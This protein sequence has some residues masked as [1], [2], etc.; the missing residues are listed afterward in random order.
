MEQSV[1]G[2]EA[3]GEGGRARRKARRAERQE[4]RGERKGTRRER[5]AAR[6]DA[7]SS[8]WEAR[9]GEVQ[10]P[11]MPGVG[12]RAAQQARREGLPD[13]S[14]FKIG[15]STRIGSDV[16]NGNG[17][18]TGNGNC[19][20]DWWMHPWIWAAVAGGAWLLMQPQKK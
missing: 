10:L 6:K 7:R 11:T 13:P 17:N 16:S 15:S 18:G 8:W 19:P 9:K 3:T 1:A 5:R 12:P 14:L 2:N 4:R 20:A